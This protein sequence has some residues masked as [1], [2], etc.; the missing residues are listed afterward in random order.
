MHSPTRDWAELPQRNRMLARLPIATRPMTGETLES[1]LS[2]LAGC[3][4]LP[5]SAWPLNQRKNPEFT[6]ML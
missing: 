5:I 4:A 3:N 6:A 1:Y 2:R